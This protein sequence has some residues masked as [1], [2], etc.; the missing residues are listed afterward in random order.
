MYT[1]YA[2]QWVTAKQPSVYVRL[3][4]LLTLAHSWIER[5]IR[6]RYQHNNNS[7]PSSEATDWLSPYVVISEIKCSESWTCDC[8]QAYHIYALLSTRHHIPEDTAAFAQLCDR[9]SMLEG[10]N[11]CN[12]GSGKGRRKILNCKEMGSSWT[13][14]RRDLPSHCAPA[15]SRPK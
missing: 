11:E 6:F 7:V 9:T 12:F 3:R 10:P 5:S 13:N 8:K 4:V 1:R 14:K 2:Y 15:P